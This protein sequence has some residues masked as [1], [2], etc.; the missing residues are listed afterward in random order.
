MVFRAP[1]AV[2]SLGMRVRD[3]VEQVGFANRTLHYD[4]AAS[5]KEGFSFMMPA[6][7]TRF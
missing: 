7:I 6:A 5:C 2:V 3:V 4:I 1:G